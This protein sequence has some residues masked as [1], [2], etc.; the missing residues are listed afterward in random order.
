M[1]ELD[2]SRRAVD[3]YWPAVDR[4]FDELPGDLYRQGRLL[5]EALAV[6]HS[7]TG[8][9]H[10]ILRRPEDPPLLHYHRWFLDDLGVADDAGR[11]ALE[12]HLFAAMVFTLALDFVQRGVRS[13]DSFVDTAWVGVADTLSRQIAREFAVVLEPD[14]PFWD[15]YRS[16]W[17]SAAA[18]VANPA[19]PARTAARRAPFM[20]SGLAV[21]ETTGWE[22]DRH[23]VL[24]MLGH[25]NAVLAMRDDLLAIRRGLGRG[26]LTEHVQVMIE[27]AGREEAAIDD[28]ARLLGALILGGSVDALE[29]R[30]RADLDALAGDA[31]ELGLPTT[32][33]YARHLESIMSRVT[34]G[35]RLDGPVTPSTRFEPASDPHREA[36]VMAE[37]FLLA[38]PSLRE[39]WEV[40][41]WGLAGAP[42][43]T[44]RFP[45][46]IVVEILGRS[47]H[48]IA[49]L[50]DDFYRQAGEKRFAYY[51]HPDLP[52][53]ET[54][55]LGVLLRLYEFSKQTEWHRSVIDEF[56][57]LLEAHVAP[58]GRLPVWLTDDPDDLLLGEGCGT[59]EANLIRGLL[60]YDAPRLAPLAGPALE[61]LISD[62][63]VRGAG[64]TVNYPRPYLLVVLGDLLSAVE[65]PDAAWRRLGAQI[66]LQA[67]R[68]RLTPMTAACLTL[69]AR[70]PSTAKQF[71]ESWITTILKGQRFDGGWSGEAMFFAPNRGR[72][73]TWYSSRLVTSAL[74][75]DAL[76]RTRSDGS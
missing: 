7:H 52:Y 39:A 34:D 56:L 59:I 10:D 24:D 14:A 62:F 40:H 8:V 2:R 76:R 42:E 26:T 69:A 74:C 67:V 63:L 57:A 48:D 31:A 75:Y 35:L 4:F 21:C 72:S 47:G 29:P 1:D 12:A 38:D 22:G 49:D 33:R 70:H 36:V 16:L 18:T 64:I 17:D 30:W 46:G 65:G 28:P 20:L 44:A 23:R 61:R 32:G 11:A 41:R 9:F 53:A 5:R 43:V 15:T 54:D 25:L 73:A 51:D 58:D 68:D 71:D 45:A 13:A 50:V 27:A 66:E 3:A 55:T 37:R 19:G 60:A 6:R